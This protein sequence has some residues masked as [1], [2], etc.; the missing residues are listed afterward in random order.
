LDVGVLIKPL[1]ETNRFLL[2]FLETAS[3]ST[4]VLQTPLHLLQNKKW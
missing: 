2:W 1:E 4:T 3:T